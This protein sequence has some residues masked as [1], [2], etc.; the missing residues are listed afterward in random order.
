[1]MLLNDL[2]VRRWTEDDFLNNKKEWQDLLDSSL[3]DKL[4]LSWDWMHSWWTIW[5]KKTTSRL[6]ILAAYQDDELVGIAPLYFSKGRILKNLIS[7][8]R[9]EFVGTMY[10]LRG[11]IRAEY[12]EFITKKEFRKSANNVLLQHI[13]GDRRWDVLILSDLVVNGETYRT[14]QHLLKN[15]RCYSRIVQ[16][17]N[18][19]VVDCTSDYSDYNCRTREKHAP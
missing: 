12:L 16:T 15:S 14:N 8:T 11:N 2:V 6:H 7:V 19:Y 5:G 1:M 18:T 17:E 13:Y 9:L 10:K 3:A 4:F